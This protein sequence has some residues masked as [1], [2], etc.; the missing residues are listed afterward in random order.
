MGR[1]HPHFSEKRFEILDTTLDMPSDWIGW[2]MTATDTTFFGN[3]IGI[4]WDYS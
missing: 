4:L 3:A 2:E 1:I